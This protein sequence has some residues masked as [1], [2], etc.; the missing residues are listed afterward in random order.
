MQYLAKYD[1]FVDDD[2]NIYVEP[3]PKDYIRCSLRHLQPRLTCDRKYYKVTIRGKTYPLHEIIAHAFIGERPAGLVID[4]IDRNSHN[5]NPSNLRY[6]SVS[7]NIANRIQTI[8]SVERDGFRRCENIKEWSRLW[9]KRN[10][11]KQHNTNHKAYY[12][13][14]SKGERYRLCADGKRRW[15]KV[16]E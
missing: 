2:C 16:N 15:I 14:V 9:R 4:H 12:S 8:L 10:P 11:D 3:K 13:H 5:N 6:C 1:C 7:E